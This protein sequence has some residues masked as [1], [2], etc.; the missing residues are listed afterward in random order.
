M[1]SP[2]KLDFYIWPLFKLIFK[3]GVKVIK[4]VYGIPKVGNPS[5][6]IY[7]LYYKEKLVNYV[8]RTF[9]CIANYF[10]FLY[11][12]GNLSVAFFFFARDGGACAAWLSLVA[13]TE[14]PPKTFLIYI[15]DTIIPPYFY[16]LSCL[17][18]FSHFLKLL[19]LILSPRLSIYKSISKCVIKSKWQ[20]SLTLTSFFMLAD[21]LSGKLLGKASFNFY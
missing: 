8:T 5:F 9:I 21:Y 14:K 3:C 16:F 13:K 18:L 2:L 12:F 7:H 15:T 4:L 17:N 10:Y 6:V 20:L 1:T 19:F 11:S